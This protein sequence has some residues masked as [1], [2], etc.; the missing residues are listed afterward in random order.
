MGKLVPL[1]NA[2]AV[3]VFV[4]LVN[5]SVSA[6]ADAGGGKPPTAI[7]EELVPLL[8]LNCCLAVAKSPFSVQEVPSKASV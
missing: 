4:D 3:I 8:P 1:E 5:S 2:P 7:A 6:V